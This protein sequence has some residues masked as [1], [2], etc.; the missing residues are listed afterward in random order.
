MTNIIID[1]ALI[2]AFY[3][4]FPKIAYKSS[5]ELILN[6]LHIICK[7]LSKLLFSY[8]YL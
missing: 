5:G 3:H 1:A 7:I 8:K 4:R 6:Q 2:A